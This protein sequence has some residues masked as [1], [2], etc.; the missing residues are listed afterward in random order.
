[1]LL[2]ELEDRFL[3][4]QVHRSGG[5]SDETFRGGESDRPARCFDANRYRRSRDPIPL[6]ERDDLL[7]FEHLY[8]PSSVK[9]S[10]T[11]VRSNS[12]VT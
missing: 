12:G 6:A 7:T 3:A 11:H 2:C 8:P 9:D 4:L 10:S 5:R 1:M